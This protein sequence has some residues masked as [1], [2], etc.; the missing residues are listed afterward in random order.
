NGVAHDNGTTAVGQRVAQESDQLVEVV[1]DVAAEHVDRH[2]GAAA[3][4]LDHLGL[5]LRAFAPHEDGV[6][7]VALDIG[8]FD[9]AIWFLHGGAASPLV[10]LQ[11]GAASIGG[12][13]RRQGDDRDAVR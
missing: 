2:L 7:D 4:R 3:G 1:V 10:R 5:H 9:A 8:G 6:A 11:Q 13:G 12:E